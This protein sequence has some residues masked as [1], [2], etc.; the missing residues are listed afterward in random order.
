MSEK[1]RADALLKEAYSKYYSDVYRFCLSFLTKDR[2]SV[3]D[4]V[5][6]TYIV[7]YKKYLN[8]EDVDYVKSF[9]YRTAENFCLKKIRELKK[10]QKHLSLD[11]IIEIPSQNED[12][13]EKLSFEE[14]SRQIARALSK[15]E[16]EIFEMKYV[17]NC[18]LEEIAK[19]YDISISNAGTKV[20]RRKKK[21]IVILEEILPK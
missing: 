3:D 5:Q 11:E 12:M 14:Y 20:Y 21:L 17:E 7:L 8:G 1:Q 16:Y 19:K 13:E 2:E 18:S 4:C 6:E 9:L 10:A 15:H